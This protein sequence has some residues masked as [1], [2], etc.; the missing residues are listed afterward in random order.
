MDDD[1]ID[2]SQP[3][4]PRSISADDQCT[5]QETTKVLFTVV[6]HLPVDHSNNA[7]YERF[8]AWYFIQILAFYLPLPFAIMHLI[9]VSPQTAMDSIE[10]VRKGL[11][12]PISPLDAFVGRSSELSDPRDWCSVCLTPVSSGINQAPA[13]SSGRITLAGRDYHAACANFWVNRVRMSLPA[14]DPL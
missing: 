9:A 14:L 11:P 4:L 6:L 12:H 3:I 5:D 1:L 2:T 8:K 10:S 13:A 7:C